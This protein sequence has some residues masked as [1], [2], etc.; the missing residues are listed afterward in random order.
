MMKTILP[1]VKNAAKSI[2]LIVFAIITLQGY[3]QTNTELVFRNPVL[4]SGTANKQGAVYLFSNITTGV[5][6]QIRLKKFSRPDIVMVDVDLSTLGWDKAFQPNFG[7]AGLVAPYQNWYI[8][9]ELTF[10]KAGTNKQQTMDTV[11]L[12]AL[13]VD[14]DGNSIS[15]YVTY[16]SPS[17]IAYSTVS[18]LTS[19]PNASLG[20]TFVCDSCGVS[21]V[22]ITCHRCGGT[23]ITN[24]GSGNNNECPDC[25]GSGMVYASCGH[26]F[27]GVTGNTVNG[28]INNFE[29]IDTSATQVMATY[30]FLKKNLIKFRYGAKSA[31]NSSD[32]SG[33]RLNSTW[34]RNFSLKASPVVS[35]LPV[36]L[37]SFSAMLE[38]NKA[39]LTWTT[40]T[41]IN[42]SHFVIEKST[43]GK[44]FND[45]GMVF[46]YGNT[47]EKMNYSFSDHVNTDQSAVIY[48]RLRSVDVDGKFTYSATRVI[49]TSKVAEN[50]ISI[51]TYP[52][53]VTNE[54]RVTIPANWQNK[55]VTYE[56]FD[57]NG[58]VSK[59]SETANSS[60]TET[61]NV[62]TLSRG[63]YIVRVTCDGRT[64][65]QKIIK[66]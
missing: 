64:A 34:F 48:Y 4:V 12:T 2:L 3:S 11:N 49:R 30:Q 44:N 1:S 25:D 6:A 31:A 43:D 66:N 40:A 61:L 17:S 35:T 51:V 8:D 22:L 5:D 27:E 16:D 47:T 36:T 46:A 42:V 41:E 33:I 23:G 32:G 19:T 37:V 20:Q 21:S 38:N 14:G 24:S 39:D 15:E 65:Q 26:P 59:K 56:M 60:Q 13:D 53:P 63:F 28:P 10:F 62:S 18:Y 55:K 29:N 9:F 57:N 45:A 7:L 58:Q 54:L 50:N 52:N